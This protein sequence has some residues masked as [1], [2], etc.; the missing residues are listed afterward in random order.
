M[1]E[2]TK[3]WDTWDSTPLSNVAYKRSWR[4]KRGPTTP[5]LDQDAL[6]RR[7]RGTPKLQRLSMIFDRF[8]ARYRASLKTS[9]ASAPAQLW[10]AAAPLFLKERRIRIQSHFVKN[11]VPH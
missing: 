10:G 5:D 3:I 4:K 8:A 7:K 1:S 11:L 2:T 6:E 9:A